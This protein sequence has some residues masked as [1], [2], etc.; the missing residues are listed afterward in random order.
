MK[1]AFSSLLAALMVFSMLPGCASKYGEQKTTVNY[2]PTC[3]R[4]IQELRQNENNVAKTT[5]GGAAMGALGGILL[6]LLA[7]GGKWEGAVVGGATGA[8][9]GTMAGNMYA[10]KQ[11]EMDDNR[12]LASYLQD[13]D[14]D[15][16]NLDIVGASARNSLQC[17][18]RQFAVLLS[19]IKAKSIA[20]EAAQARYNEIVSGR[21][22]AIALLGNAATHARDLDQQYEQALLAEQQ[23]LQTPAK[24][25]QGQVAIS[26]KASA[27][28]T[29][30]KRKS[31]L[32]QTAASLERE[33]SAASAVTSQQNMEIKAAMQDI[34]ET[35][36]EART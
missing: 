32:T 8:V 2:Y 6:G 4:P 10:R 5:A 12:R 27:I 7:S 20:Q 34:Q 30:R 21:E 29:A 1:K 28:S 11:Q 25:A 13:I 18:D 3:Y 33:K 14:G 22:E 15:I 19:Q 35:M 23:Q 17:Y 24:Q 16:S 9:A 26:R 31:A 36:N